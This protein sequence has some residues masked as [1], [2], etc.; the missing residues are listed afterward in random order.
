MPQV[1]L[2]KRFDH[3]LKD[4]SMKK[5]DV[6]IPWLEGERMPVMKALEQCLT[7]RELVFLIGPEGDFSPEEAAQAKLF[8]AIPVS[9][10]PTTLKVDTAASLVVGLSMAFFSAGKTVGS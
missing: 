8:G 9:L 4:L 1:T 5:A 3:L 10:G 6:I 7:A 2:P